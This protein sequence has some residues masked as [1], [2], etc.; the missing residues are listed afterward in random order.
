MARRHH[1]TR[2]ADRS[3][4]NRQNAQQLIGSP[5]SVVQ[6]QHQGTNVRTEGLVAEILTQSA[7][8]PRGI[9]VRLVDGT[10]GRI[11]LA[12]ASQPAE[13][14]GRPRR[15]HASL[16]DFMVPVGPQTSPLPPPLH[17]ATRPRDPPLSSFP[18]TEHEWACSACTFVNS[19]L[20]PD[21]ELCQTKRPR[22]EGPDETKDPS[23]FTVVGMATIHAHTT[24]TPH[25]SSRLRL[26]RDQGTTTCDSLRSK[27]LEPQS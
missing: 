4:G 27:F 17:P 23:S 21:C 25:G 26:D 13:A 1:H 3:N 5:V 11:A 6:K 24:T 15:R 20:L 9:K 18:F 22:Y 2:R 16:A 12:S 14:E 19:G 10:V 7:F 8:H